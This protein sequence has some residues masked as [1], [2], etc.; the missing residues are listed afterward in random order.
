MDKNFSTMIQ[1]LLDNPTTQKM[2]NIEGEVEE[3][4]EDKKDCLRKIDSIFYSNDVY[5]LF[6]LVCQEI[7]NKMAEIGLDKDA[8]VSRKHLENLFMRSLKID[9]W[10][11]AHKKL[12]A[13]YIP[14]TQENILKLIDLEY[15]VE[16][17]MEYEKV[18]L[19]TVK[20]KKQKEMEKLKNVS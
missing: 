1:D 16:F 14:M 6:E 20:L 10:L 9:I 18:M 5:R 19:F 2:K 7:K 4:F 13:Y 3:F 12:D 17:V 15:I 8:G 11:L